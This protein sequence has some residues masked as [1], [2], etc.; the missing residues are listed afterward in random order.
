MSY[1]AYELP[2]QVLTRAAERL[3]ISILGKEAAVWTIRT[4]YAGKS[5]LINPSK[6]AGAMWC[7]LYLLTWRQ[8]GAPACL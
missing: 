8:H 3:L 5:G 2:L 6:Q 1:D 7:L 4:I